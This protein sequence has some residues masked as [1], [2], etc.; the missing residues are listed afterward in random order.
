[1]RRWLTAAALAAFVL[2]STA[3]GSGAAQR[4]RDRLDV[5]TAVVQADQL[6]ALADQGFE[7]SDVREVAGATEVQLVLS[8]AQRAELSR[9]GIRTKL[10]RVKGGKTVKE[11]AAAQSENGF[12]VWRSWDE[13][14]GFRDQMYAVA[15]DNPQLAKLVKLGTTYQGRE[16]LAIKLTQ[17]ARGQADGQPAGGALQLHAARARVDRE[18]GQPAPDVPLHRPLAGERLPRSSGC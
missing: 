15:R 12:T 11:F 16:L 4:A 2:G 14:G 18:R 8:K 1:M 17:G 6:R 10:T 7:L 9:D 13:P 5:Y 3:P